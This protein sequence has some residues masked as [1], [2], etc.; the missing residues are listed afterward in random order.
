MS[1][2]FANIHVKYFLRKLMHI[3]YESDKLAMTATAFSK[4]SHLK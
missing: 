4:L 1:L 2:T 3:P